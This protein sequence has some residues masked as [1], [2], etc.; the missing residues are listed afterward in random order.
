MQELDLRSQKV[1]NNIDKMAGNYLS[2]VKEY[3]VD[4]KKETMASITHQFDIAKAYSDDK[5][6]LSIQ[7]Y[8][9]VCRF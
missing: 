8:E 3:S 2:N 6:Q 5:V 1:M 9:L 4:K 7:T